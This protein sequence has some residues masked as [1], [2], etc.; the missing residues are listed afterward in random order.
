MCSLSLCLAKERF[1]SPR[2]LFRHPRHQSQRHRQALEL[3]VWLE[4]EFRAVVAGIFLVRGDFDHALGQRMESPSNPSE[5]A[6]R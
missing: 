2:K 5:D 1:R 6:V 4:E 3:V